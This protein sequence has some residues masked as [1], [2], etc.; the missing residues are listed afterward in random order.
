MNSRQNKTID[1]SGGDWRAVSPY[2][3]GNEG[4]VIE[5][6]LA[7]HRVI[8]AQTTF[9]GLRDDIDGGIAVQQSNALLMAAA[10]A[11]LEACQEALRMI[12]NCTGN[13]QIGVA[14]KLE[15]AIKRATEACL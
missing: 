1:A 9:A 5:T 15:R 13:W 4:W 3:Y 10:P 6:E 12:R 7:H 2:T 11:L 14:E 8:L